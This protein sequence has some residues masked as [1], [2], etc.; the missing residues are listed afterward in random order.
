MVVVVVV[1]VGKCVWMRM[2][3]MCVCMCLGV[4]SLQ[5]PLTGRP[6]QT[7][8]FWARWKTQRHTYTLTL[9]SIWKWHGYSTNN[10]CGTTLPPI[11]WTCIS[12]HG[13]TF[14]SIH[15]V[16]FKQ[17]LHTILSYWVST[18]WHPHSFWWNFQHWASAVKM[19][20]SK[21]Y[22]WNVSAF[23]M[24]VSLCSGRYVVLFMCASSFTE[25]ISLCLHRGME[26][27]TYSLAD[28]LSSW[29]CTQRERARH[30]ERAR[31]RDH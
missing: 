19:W 24:R 29:I 26:T 20:L 15:F 22:L 9:L 30:G 12:F 8:Y 28:S 2:V 10:H 16:I 1:V 23:L 5:S 6:E 27:F 7:T 21:D 17:S 18:H 14:P 11:P 4:L 31:E 13:Y 3:G 25:L